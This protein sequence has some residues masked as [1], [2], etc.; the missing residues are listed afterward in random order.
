MTDALGCS[1]CS[2]ISASIEARGGIQVEPTLRRIRSVG[3]SRTP[4]GNGVAVE[5]RYRLIILGAG[6]SQPAGFPLAGELWEEIRQ[7]APELG[8]RAAEFNDDLNAYIEYRRDCDGEDQVNF[9]DFM[10]FLDIEHFLGLRGAD[11]WSGEGNEG[12]LVV[13]TLIGAILA[14]CIARLDEIP[15]LYLEFARRLQAGDVVVTFNYDTLLE[16]ALDV[17]GKPYRLFP[18]RFKSTRDGTAISVREDNGDEIVVLKL[19][20]SIDWF[21]Q[22]AFQLKEQRHQQLGADPPHD[23]IFSHADELRLQPLVDGVRSETDPLRT[24]YR[25]RNLAA[26][27][28][29]T[30]MFKATPRML[31]PSSMKIVYANQV[32]NFWSSIAG[33]GE[34]RSG[35][36]I[37]GFSL[38]PQDEYARQIVYPLVR[39]YQ[40]LGLGAT[41]LGMRRTPL[42]LISKFTNEDEIRKRYRFVDWKSATLHGGGFGRETLD[43]IFQ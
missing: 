24:V 36:A 28:N 8:G 34:L 3:T 6:F 33:G 4:I 42:A 39:S 11:T 31:P 23:I 29:K 15:E 12:T 30:I 7:L 17:V 37:I 5:K 25:V 19:H 27:Y 14:D 43:L 21:D 40:R 35:M 38:P 10:R 26:L 9:E 20:G 2:T 41:P 1:R 18:T 32:G 16:N 13:K 22:K